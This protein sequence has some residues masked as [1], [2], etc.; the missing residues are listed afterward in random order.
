M[1]ASRVHDIA[2]LI[3]WKYTSILWSII[4]FYDSF[5]GLTY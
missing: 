3:H 1:Y 5:V 2:L 4:L